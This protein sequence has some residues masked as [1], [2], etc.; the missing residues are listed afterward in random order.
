MRAGLTRIGVRIDNNRVALTFRRPAKGAWGG[1]QRGAAVGALAPI[2][3][4]AVFPLPGTT[5]LG[6]L[7]AP[8]T[9]LG[10][11]IYGAAAAQPRAEVQAAEDAIGRALSLL[12]QT[13]PQGRLRD[14]VVE[15][16]N[17]HTGHS[18]SAL[19]AAEPVHVDAVLELV[20]Q[21]AGLDGAWRV[22]PPSIAFAE[23]RA[24]LRDAAG[25]TLLE[26]KILCS[27]EQRTYFEWAANDAALF[28]A[29]MQTCVEAL[30]EKIVADFFLVYPSSERRIN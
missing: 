29:T 5:L 25:E 11:M 27:G 16:G 3:V 19:D 15:L 13:D 14:R 30:A 9:A 21:R 1:A 24:R 26:E 8:V 20:D 18:F 23:T 10:G 28:T 4:G 2:A 22:D 6:V 17:E 12:Q 7:V